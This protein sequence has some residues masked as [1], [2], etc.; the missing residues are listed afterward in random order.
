MC[1]LAV[2]AAE[3]AAESKTAA[4]FDRAAGRLSQRATRSAYFIVTRAAA[5]LSVVAPGMAPQDEQSG[6][7]A[8]AEILRLEELGQA[9]DVGTFRAASK[10]DRALGQIVGRLGPHDI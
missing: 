7:F 5:S 9:D 4:V 10:R 2:D 1:I 8:L 6:I 3:H